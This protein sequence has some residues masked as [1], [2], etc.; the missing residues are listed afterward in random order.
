MEETMTF[1]PSSLDRLKVNRS[2]VSTA[3][4]WHSV[5]KTNSDNPVHNSDS[6][7]WN[8]FHVWVNNVAIKG[9]RKG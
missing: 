4:E 7:E 6:L 8:I 5:Y 3:I 1:R 9:Y 2:A